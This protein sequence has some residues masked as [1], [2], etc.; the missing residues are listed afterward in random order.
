MHLLDLTLPTP[1]ANLA[2]DEALLM[3]DQ[4]EWLRFWESPTPLVVLGRSSRAA[5]EVDLEFCRQ[6]HVRVLRRVSGGGT[7][8]TGPGC[9]M[10]AL[11]I[12]LEK[13]P[14]LRSIDR[15]HEFVLGRISTGLQKVSNK[16]CP[17]GVSDLATSN[18]TNRTLRKFSGNSVRVVRSR[19][20]YHGTLLYAA[21]LDF[22]S[23]ALQIPPREPDYR[24]QRSHADFIQNLLCEKKTLQTILTDTWEAHPAKLPEHVRREVD[25]LVRDR[26]IL[27]SWNLAR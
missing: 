26:Y 1:E 16:I 8:L 13:R 3:S 22:I 15:A 6:Q 21:D 25:L 24:S 11:L 14:E 10:Y 4:Q 9:L 20:L 7:I 17:A 5:H 23:K 12:D 18:E 2:L 19:L 27:D